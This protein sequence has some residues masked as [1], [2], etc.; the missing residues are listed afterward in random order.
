MITHPEGVKGELLS[1]VRQ[2]HERLGGINITQIGQANAKLHTISF[3][4]TL[5]Q[6]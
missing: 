5:R 4:L 2:E 6:W 3:F 1:G